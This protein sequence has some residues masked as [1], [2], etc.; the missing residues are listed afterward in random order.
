[1]PTSSRC[2]AAGRPPAGH[3]CSGKVPRDELL[4]LERFAVGRRSVATAQPLLGSR[5][6]G[7]TMAAEQHQPI[8][9]LDHVICQA[10]PP[11][12]LAGE[13]V[14]VGRASLELATYLRSG[15]VLVVGSFRSDE[16]D[17][18]HPLRQLLG[19]LGRNRRVQRLDLGRFSRAEL[20]E[21][22]AGLLGTDPPGRLVDDVYARSGGN[23]FFAEE[24]V[25]AGGDPAALP[26]S[27]REVLLVRVV[28]LGHRTQRVLQVAAAAGLPELAA[29]HTLGLAEQTRQQGRPDPAAWT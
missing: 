7:A 13:V 17:R 16:L 27:L 2:G 8:P 24:L 3:R 19:E 26:S 20:A 5:P 9:R 28:R 21:Q 14:P 22:L 11:L 10:L 12:Q 4:R 29:W 15:R 6:F 18:L 1:M 23:P 25:L